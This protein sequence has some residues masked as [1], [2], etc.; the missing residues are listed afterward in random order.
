MLEGPETRLTIDCLNK[1]LNG[2]SI[3]D[4]VFCGGKYTDEVPE[5]FEVFDKA[6]PLKVNN[7]SCKGKFI[8]FTLID[9]EDQE[10]YIMH[11]LKMTDRWQK[12]YDEYCKWF[13]ELND[14]STI[15]FR[16]SRS[17]STISFTTDRNVLQDKLDQLGPDIMTKE[18][19]LPSF[20]N[21]IVKFSKRNITAFLMDQKVISGCGN[22][23]KSEVL[24]YASVSPLRKV[25]D[26]NDREI[27]LVY[28]ALRIIP[29]I[30][31]NKKGFSLKDYI[32]KNQKIGYYSEELKVYGK[33]HAKRTKTADGKT[34]YWDPN[35][36]I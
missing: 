10:Q 24:W 22:Y 32:N 6:L 12:E 15:W 19:S 34:T 2:K 33:K 8:Y 18:F 31:Y 30:S 26:L 29:R 9:N 1:A 7:V 23:I 3:T 13:V 16:S 27:E 28:E 20:R 5:G 11:N 21:L 14:G 4:W 36:Q 35:R 17:L 25:G